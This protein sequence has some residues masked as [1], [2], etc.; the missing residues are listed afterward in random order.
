MEV[1]AITWGI[2]QSIWERMGNVSLDISAWG[3]NDSKRE[4]VA[5]GGNGYNNLR[6]LV[7]GL[8]D[9]VLLI[10]LYDTQNWL[11]FNDNVNIA[12]RVTAF[13]SL[14]F[15]STNRVEKPESEINFKS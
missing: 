2:P 3:F 5:M 6:G 4:C 10:D 14:T 9:D 15:P 11:F 13:D 7:K 1:A 12:H 8:D